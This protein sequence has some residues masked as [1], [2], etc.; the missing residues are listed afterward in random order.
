MVLNSSFVDEMNR[1]L[2]NIAGEATLFLADEREGGYESLL[3]Y[4]FYR[5]FDIII[6]SNDKSECN[7]T[8]EGLI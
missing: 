5:D 7:L 6:T 1:R 8:I 4:G 3:I 2:T